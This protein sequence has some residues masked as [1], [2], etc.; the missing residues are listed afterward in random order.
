[1]KRFLCLII[2]L[3]MVLSLCACNKVSSDKTVINAENEAEV[4]AKKLDFPA[5]TK[6][7]WEKSENNLGARYIFTLEEFNEKL[8]SASA[9]LA[10]SE[11]KEHFDFKNW[12]KMADNL[13]D[14][15][16]IKYSSYYYATDTLTITAAVENESGKV[17]NLGCGTSYSQFVEADAE[18]Q[19][20]IML[21][22]AIISMVA[23]GY[24]EDALEFLYYIFFDSAKSEK[25]FFYNNGVYMM[26]LSKAE[27]EEGSVVLFMTS[28]CKDEILTE[29]EL[30]DYT[31]YEESA[32]FDKE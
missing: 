25:G 28:P 5:P 20:T 10:K 31:K 8:N 6:L 4:S 21:T 27:G 22:A 12:V 32:R 14:D 15:N 18:Y 23:G 9:K 24:E 17:M 1:M 19:Y 13:V 29:W 3:I 2:T 30:I 26:N 7:M 16:G 11:V